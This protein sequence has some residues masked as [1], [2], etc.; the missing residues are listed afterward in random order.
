MAGNGPPKTF[1]SS[2]FYQTRKALTDS[3]LGWRELD[4]FWEGELSTSALS[5]ATAVVALHLVDP[6]KNRPMVV[7]GLHWLAR[8]ANEDG[9]WG[10]TVRSDSNVSTTALAWGALGLMDDPIIHPALTRA[11]A[12]LVR[13]AGGVTPDHITKTILKRYGKDRTFSIP[14]LTMLALCGRLGTGRGAW[15]QVTPLPFE[16]AAL[17]RKWFQFIRLPVVSYALPAL[18]AIG[19]TI[20]HHR[21]TFNPVTGVARYL[22][23]QKTLQLLEQIQPEDGGFLEAVPLTAFVV[24]SLASMDLRDHPVVTKGVA[25]LCR[26]VR[27]DG[28]WPIDTHLATWVTTLSVNALSR[29][30]G[31]LEDEDKARLLEWL[32]NQQYRETHPYTDAEPGGWAWTPLPGG[33]PDADDTS[34]AII[35]LAN[36]E[37]HPGEVADAAKMGLKW[38][39]RLQNL[40]GG[41]PTFCRGWGTL[42]FDRSC[43]DIT[44]HA[45]QAFSV[46]LKRGYVGGEW[47]DFIKRA[48][49]YLE[50]AQREDGSWVPLWF[51]NQAERQNENPVYGTARVLVGLQALREI[52]G[53]DEVLQTM[54]LRGRAWLRA[55][56]NSDGG[57]GGRKGLPSTIEETALATEALASGLPEKPIDH[58]L[59]QQE[60]R[61]V[62]DAITF[63]MG[64]VRA[65]GEL[66][67]APIGFYFAN[68]WYFERL[69]PLVFAT[70]AFT[71]VS[72]KKAWFVPNAPGRVSIP[73]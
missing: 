6:E 71:A 51:G 20:Q 22:T 8:N 62:S 41:L 47:D 24:M 59:V 55:Q 64:R 63:L 15:R 31:A 39:A 72:A 30:E 50:S 57:F 4:G 13:E 58:S 21:P 36:L 2:D 27:H 61:C 28:S 35:A 38:L 34:G 49:L 42:P 46:W 3:L 70:G 48:L 45:L 44:A 18:I 68:L 65:K 7:D 67:A 11:E 1:K 43:P 26:L 52:D 14:I 53:D 69:Y 25:F 12:W 33:V 10:D 73:A 32:L 23:K 29:Q 54:I 17:P 5:T 19:Q 60:W 37:R 16:L 66:E 9:G 40:D 56:A